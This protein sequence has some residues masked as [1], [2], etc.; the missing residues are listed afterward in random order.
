MNLHGFAF[1]VA[2]CAGG[3]MAPG[4]IAE[5]ADLALVL[6]VDSSGSI[7]LEDFYLQK[8]GYAAA[9]R[10]PGVHRALETAGTVD[11]AVLF[12][13]DS[14]FP[15]QVMPWQRITGPEDAEQFGL[16]IL[17]MPREVSGNTGLSR[18]L[19]VA[20]DLLEAS[21]ACA[22]RKV[23]N[24]SGDGQETLAFRPRWSIPL[25][26]VRERAEAM[27][28]TVNALAIETEVADLGQWY[29]ARLITG[30]GAFVMKVAGYE[31]FADAIARKLMR[32]IPP[33]AMT[34]LLPEK[35]TLR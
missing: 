22:L 26:N 24:V 34:S 20:L 25:Q 27:G 14:D 7:S 31:T 1:S 15:S 10:H 16:R 5:C 6:A 17:S 33:I 21:E 30:P 19:T 9:F 23:V 2:L 4:V 12:W 28:V 13:G 3:L 11:V 8:A 18:A 32:E 35:E 29:E